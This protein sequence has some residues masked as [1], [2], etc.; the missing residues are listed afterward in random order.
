MIADHTP[1]FSKHDWEGRTFIQLFNSKT[2]QTEF[3]PK[4]R[5]ASPWWVDLFFPMLSKSQY[6]MDFKVKNA[7]W[8]FQVERE[9]IGPC[10]PGFQ[11]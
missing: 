5:K 6:P 7:D 2:Q 1:Y 8:T 11:G 10:N 4:I 9:I 3:M